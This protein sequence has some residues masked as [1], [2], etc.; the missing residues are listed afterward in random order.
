M[1]IE[2]ISPT[3]SSSSDLWLDLWAKRLQSRAEDHPAAE[4]PPFAVDATAA[5]RV[6]VE[7][8][9][10]TGTGAQVVRFVDSDSGRLISEIPHRQV[11][12]LVADLIQ[13]QH[14]AKQRGGDDHGQH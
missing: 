14:E 10:H 12:D 7:L 3:T 6:D 13:Q 4:A 11:L 8:S 1:E 2:P 9:E 5:D